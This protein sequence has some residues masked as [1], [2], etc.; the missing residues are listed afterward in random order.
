MTRMWYQS[1]DV[2]PTIRT[3]REPSD[4]LTWVYCLRLCRS[5]IVRLCS[6]VSVCRVICVCGGVIC[7]LKV[8]CLHGVFIVGRAQLRFLPF[9]RFLRLRVVLRPHGV[10]AAVVAGARYQ[11]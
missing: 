11:L 2:T 7:M 5:R 6:V 10:W 4:A 8:A 1:F 9:L 3:G